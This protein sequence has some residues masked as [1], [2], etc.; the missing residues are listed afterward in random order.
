MNQKI[1]PLE[2]LYEDK[3]IINEDD[4]RYEVE[5][6]ESIIPAIIRPIKKSS[7]FPFT[8]YIFFLA[9]IGLLIFICIF[10]IK[11]F[12]KKKF[13]SLINDPFITPNVTKHEYRKI[14]FNNGLELLLVQTDENDIAGGAIVIDS[15]YNDL[16]YEKGYLNL[17]LYSLINDNKY[18]ST[19]LSD[20]FGKFNYYIN[21]T[22]SYFRFQILNEGFFNYL[23][24]FSLILNYNKV[25]EELNISEVL[26]KIE[27]KIDNKEQYLIDYL[28]YGYSEN[29]EAVYRKGK[30]EDFNSDYE[31]IKNNIRDTLDKLIKPSKIKIVLMSRFKMSKMESKF[32]NYFHYLIDLKENVANEFIYNNTF[33]KQKIISYIHNRKSFIKINYYIDKR[34]NDSYSDLIIN[35]GYFNYLK[36]ILEGNKQYLFD[37][38][39]KYILN[40]KSIST[41]FEVILKSKIKFSIKIELYNNKYYF[42]DV[43]FNVYNYINK[44]KKNIENLKVTD[45]RYEEIKKILNQSFFFQEDSD[46]PA[47]ASYNFALDLFK[48]KANESFYFLKDKWIPPLDNETDIVKFKYYYNQ[49]TPENS[50]IIFGRNGNENYIETFNSSHEFKLN[51]TNI[52]FNK[53]N[54]IKKIPTLSYV[55]ENLDIS[56][57]KNF[58]DSNDITFIK[59]EYIHEDNYSIEE[60]LEDSDNKD[61]ALTTSNMSRFYFKKDTSFKIPKVRVSLELY[62]PF[63]IPGDF[64]NFNSFSDNLLNNKAE[65][66]KNCNYYLIMLYKTYLNKKIIN[67]QLHDAILAG[68]SIN[69]GYNSYNLFIEIFAYS[70][71]IEIILN[72][73]KNI[74][75]DTTDL[76]TEYSKNSNLYNESLLED[77]LNLNTSYYSTYTRFLFTNIIANKTLFDKYKFVKEFNEPFYDVCINSINEDICEI[78]TNFII[79]THVYGYYTLKEA[80]KIAELFNKSK[81]NEIN[82]NEYVLT[83]AGY[84]KNDEIKAY[85][86]INLTRNI[87]KLNVNETNYINSSAFI[88]YLY[89]GEY[90]LTN[91]I[92][93]NLFSKMLSEKRNYQGYTLKVNTFLH[94]S[95]YLQ[96]IL[97]KDNEAKLDNVTILE[98]II[99]EIINN[100][101]IRYKQPIDVVGNRFDYLKK[102]T[103]IALIIKRDTFY[104]TAK[105]YF[106]EVTH[107]PDKEKKSIHELIDPIELEKLN[108]SLVKRV[109][110]SSRVDFL[111][112]SIAEYI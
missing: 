32:K 11:L 46:E 31:N 106:N 94:N 86:F 50:V 85:N 10:L 16:T 25:V 57:T 52:F 55:K 56:F 61:V 80:K 91:N 49:L 37:G 99:S 63:L 84:N 6:N 19:E 74:I 62:H 93:I 44:I 13:Y 95:T 90:N 87:T 109:N 3:N 101:I 65:T 92:K 33:T 27:Y 79:D 67:D 104:K 20:Y 7:K 112:N 23:Q 5:D 41:D 28:I 54:G 89:Y 82:F 110:N 15:G 77:D 1:N 103:A 66:T 81:N 39:N 70:D 72:K 35:A 22:F 38:P 17:S 48:K 108:N 43:L 69:I 47:E 73:I 68:N 12:T 21:D 29:G 8:F 45:E 14:I 102:N 107:T 96:F 24:N 36:Y 97:T 4:D 2:L 100:Q 83:R 59:N 98:G 34:E 88:R 75:T 111:P 18:N 78:I 64:S 30:K 71:K 42:Q 60:G 58:S 40:F 51:C 26:S 9:L 53:S 76:F 105:Y